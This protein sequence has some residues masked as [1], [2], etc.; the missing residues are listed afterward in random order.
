MTPSTD[1]APATT[2]ELQVYLDTYPC[3]ANKNGTCASL[4]RASP[5]PQREILTAARRGAAYYFFEPV[6]ADVRR[7]EY[8]AD[9]RSFSA[10]VR[11]AGSLP[12]FCPSL[13]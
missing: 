3:E 7:V 12:A 6:R 1:L 9:W 5:T 2:S 4:Y 10:T 8:R 11:R 13:Y